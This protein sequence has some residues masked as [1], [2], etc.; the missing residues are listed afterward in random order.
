MVLECRYVRLPS[1]RQI[2]HITGWSLTWFEKHVPFQKRSRSVNAPH[3]K[4]MTTAD[5]SALLIWEGG[6][7]SRRV[8]YEL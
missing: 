1:N 4:T 5:V 6:K 8:R 7:K 3:V 2:L